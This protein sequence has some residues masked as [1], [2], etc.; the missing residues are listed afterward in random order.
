M[1]QMKLYSQHLSPHAATPAPD[2]TP[3]VEM[4]T[5]P[6][7]DVLLVLIVML[8]ITIPVPLNFVNLDMPSKQA[9]TTVPEVVV[10]QIDVQGFVLWD[11]DRL[12]NLKEVNERMAAAAKQPVQPEIHLKPAPDAPY[13]F[14]AGVLVMAQK[15]GLL[16]VGVVN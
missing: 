2:P 5:T 1:H 10:L 3:L 9:I 4:N 16:K 7:I 11:G 6:L 12:T 13:D 14:V 15:T 8:I